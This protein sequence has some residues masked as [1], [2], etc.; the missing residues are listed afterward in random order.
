[1]ISFPP[2]YVAVKGFHGYFWNLET[3]KLYSLKTK[4]ILRPIKLT[5]RNSRFNKWD[6]DGYRVSVDGQPRVLFP[7]KIP[8]KLTSE[9]T[10]PVVEPVTK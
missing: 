4:G 3:C 10:I 1:M 2:N 7:S 6:E 9:Y 5:K 8:F